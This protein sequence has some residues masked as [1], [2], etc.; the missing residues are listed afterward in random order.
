MKPE[1]IEKTF[2]SDTAQNRIAKSGAMEVLQKQQNPPTGAV[3][4][5]NAIYLIK[6][7]YAS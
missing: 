3:P 2:S 6:Y 1:T 4:D 5:N 7:T